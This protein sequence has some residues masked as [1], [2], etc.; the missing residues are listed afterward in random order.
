MV[1]AGRL[2]GIGGVAALAVGAKLA[3]VSIIAGMAG[4]AFRGS[5]LPGL[6]MAR[7]AGYIDMSACELESS[8][9]MVKSGRFPAFSGMTGLAVGAKLAFVS[10]VAGMAGVAGG[11]R[12]GEDRVPGRI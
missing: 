2:P 8:P 9:R 6:G 12:G 5:A 10:I 11:R 4:N 7:L 3:F 1:K